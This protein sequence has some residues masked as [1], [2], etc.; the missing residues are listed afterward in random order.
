MALLRPKKPAAS[1]LPVAETD[2]HCHLLPAWDDGPRTLEI[3][4]QMAQEAAASGLKRIVTTPHVG[5]AFRGVEKPARDIAAAVAALQK[6]IDEAQIELQVVPGAEILLGSVE[7]LE[8]MQNSPEWTVGGQGRYVLVE[9]PFRTWPD[10]GDNLLYQIGLRGVT[11]IVAHPE[12][13]LNIAQD[14]KKMQNAVNG[15]ALLQLTAGAILGEQGREVKAC[16]RQL[17]QAGLV[18]LVS[19]DAHGPGQTWPGAAAATLVSTVGQA[20]AR[21]ILE[22]NP[23]R[24]LEG[25]RASPPPIENAPPRARGLGRFLAP[26]RH[27]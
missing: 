12:R 13:Y 24:V 8:Q 19:S 1:D 15:G 20:A 18:S 9:S 6:A 5:R 27:G 2:L 25:R 10:W 16:C 14:A 4:L 21:V 3:S 22:E 7:I 11:P 23:R 17:L 26:R